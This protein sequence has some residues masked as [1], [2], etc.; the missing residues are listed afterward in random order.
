M[1][2]FFRCSF[3]SGSDYPTEGFI[4]EGPFCGASAYLAT[5]N[6]SSPTKNVDLGFITGQGTVHLGLPRGIPRGQSRRGLPDLS[7][8]MGQGESQAFVWG[9][10][11]VIMSKL[12]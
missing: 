2:P 1:Q 7:E 11:G 4:C 3:F 6:T 9:V 8:Y 5:S 12:S 10:I